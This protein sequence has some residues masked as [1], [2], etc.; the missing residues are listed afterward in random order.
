MIDIQPILSGDRL[1]LS[2]L[3]TAVENDTPAG[4]EALSALFPHTGR[5]HLIGVTGAPGTGK[6]SLV[7]RLARHFR[8]QTGEDLPRVAVVAVDPSSPAPPHR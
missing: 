5:G 8:S 4:R 6:S 7:N 3:L 2:R 1:A